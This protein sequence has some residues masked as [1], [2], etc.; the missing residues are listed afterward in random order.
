MELALGETVE[1]ERA[2]MSYQEI[3]ENTVRELAQAAVTMGEMKEP[4]DLK[5]FNE[6]L[7]PGIAQIAAERLKLREATMPDALAVEVRAWRRADM[8]TQG[9][10]N[11]LR[12]LLAEIP[13]PS[14]GRWNEL[15]AKP[16]K[17]KAATEEARAAAAY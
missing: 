17:V 13:E 12:P 11:M 3:I 15:I 10:L 1:N 7:A 5:Y 2:I 4:E 9:L 14:R 6:V 16:E 8:Q